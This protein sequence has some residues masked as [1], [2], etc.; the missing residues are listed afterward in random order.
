MKE[1]VNWQLILEEQLH[2]L[3]HTVT[4]ASGLGAKVVR[5]TPASI[6][7]FNNALPHVNLEDI[8]LPIDFYQLPCQTESEVQMK[9]SKLFNSV[10]NKQC[11]VVDTSTSGYL[12]NPVA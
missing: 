11:V 3:K 6:E 7:I 9:L 8:K 1:F 12:K 4:D 5:E 10:P 2:K